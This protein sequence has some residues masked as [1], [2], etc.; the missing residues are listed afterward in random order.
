MPGE[1]I[2]LP[3]EAELLLLATGDMRQTAA[4]ARAVRDGWFVP[5]RP[6]EGA[7]ASGASATATAGARQLARHPASRPDVGRDHAVP[8]AARA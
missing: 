6:A 8:E 1:R 4:A 7:V 5:L 2:T 3:R